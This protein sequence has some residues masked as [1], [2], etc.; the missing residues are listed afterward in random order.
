MSFQKV[1]FSQNILNEIA[2][3]KV[4]SV[5]QIKSEARSLFTYFACEKTK[6]L[7]KKKN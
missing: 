6:K 2:I 7:K 4:D 3:E 5:G 1:R